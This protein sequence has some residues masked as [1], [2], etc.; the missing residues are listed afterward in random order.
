MKRKTGKII[1]MY[2][3]LFFCACSNLTNP[4]QNKDEAR[5]EIT[6]WNWTDS[7]SINIFS[8]YNIPVRVLLGEHLDSFKVHV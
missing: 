7:V 6:N 8:T 4:F 1:L 3:G 5:A 2:V